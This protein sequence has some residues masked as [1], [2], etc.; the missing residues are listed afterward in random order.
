MYVLL[1]MQEVLEGKSRTIHQHW[2]LDILHQKI[3]KDGLRKRRFSGK[4]F[5]LNEI[6]TIC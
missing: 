1:K 6:N 5:A 2:N 4:C 3:A